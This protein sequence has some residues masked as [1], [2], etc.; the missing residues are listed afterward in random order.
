M[1]RSLKLLKAA[2]LIFAVFLPS[3]IFAQ[4]VGQAVGVSQNAFLNRDGRDGY[5]EQGGDVLLG[6]VISTGNSG[7]VQILFQDGTKIAISQNSSLVI[8]RVLFDSSN[9]A[10]EFTVNAVGGAFRFLSGNSSPSSYSIRTSNATMGVRGTAFDFAASARGEV[11]VATFDGEVEL[12]NQ[13]G[14]CASIPGGCSTAGIDASGQFITPQNKKERS[15][16]LDRGFPYIRNQ[17]FLR[18]DYRTRVESCGGGDGA[19]VDGGDRDRAAAP[20]PSP[21]DPAPS[22]PSTGG[23][24]AGG[25]TSAGSGGSTAGGTDA[26]RGGPSAPG[27]ADASGGQASSGG[28]G[29]ASAGGGGASAGK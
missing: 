1:S 2:F 9:T 27:D 8:E 23:A 11:R 19:G 24:R 5:L 29:G 4:S 10:S 12:C 3:T 14:R 26:G 17:S 6:D 25:N 28:P 18:Q 7:Q 21:T 22:N 20:S 15:A 13:M 16:F